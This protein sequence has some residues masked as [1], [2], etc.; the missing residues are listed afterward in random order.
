MR[1]MTRWFVPAFLFILT[2]PAIAQPRPARAPLEAAERRLVIPGTALDRLIRENSDVGMLR[3][4]EVN[5]DI[6]IPLWLRVYWRKKHP[7]G[8]YSASDPT[9]GYPLVLKELWE[10]MLTHQDLQ[11]GAPDAAEAAPL[12]KTASVSGELRTSGLQTKPRSES[13]IRVNPRNP[14]QIIAASNNIQSG[15]VQAQF[16]STDGGAT[17]SQSYLPLRS[18][19]VLHSDPTVEWTSDGTAWATTLGIVSLSNLKLLLYKSTDQGTTWTF[20]SV[21]SGSTQQNVD[22]QMT[23]VDSS[24]I[25]PYR[26][27]MYAIWHNNS[28]VFMNRRTGGAWQTPVQVSGS[29]TTGTGIGAD[30]RT[31]SAGEVYAFW[32]DTG[33]RKLYMVKSTNGGAAY[34][35]PSIVASTF[36]SYDIGVPAMNDRRV[37]VYATA[38]AYKTSLNNYVFLSWNDLSGASGC[39]SAANEPG[40]ST[41]SACKTRIWFTR[42]TNGGTSWS[43]PVM[44]NNQAS[45]N[46]QFNPWMVVDET[47]GR[48]AIVY[49]DTVGDAGRKKTDIYYQS[50]ADF[51][52][53]FS[54]AVKVTTAQTDESVAGADP[55]GN[56]YGDY[57]GLS[58]SASLFFPSWTD[59]RNNASEEIWTAAITDNG[60]TGP[61]PSIKPWGADRIPPAPPWWQTDDIWVD[62]DADGIPNEPGEPSRG[63]AN[64]QLTARITNRGS[65]AATNF[66]VTFRFKPYTTSGSA[67]AE[68]IAS[69]DESGSLAAGASKN[70]T[71]AWDLTDAFIQAHFTSMFWAADHFCVQ[72]T[73][74]STGSGTFDDVNLTDNFAQN[75]FSNV[76][77]KSKKASAK[78][79]LYN[80][81]DRV[82]IARLDV[83]TD[84]KGWNVRFDGIRNPDQIVMQPKQWIA[85]EAL[86]EADANTP[87]LARG[88][89]VNVDVSQ[90]LDGNIV[91]GLTMGLRPEEDFPG[92]TTPIG[93]RYALYGGVAT[94]LNRPVS[95]MARFYDPGETFLAFLERPFSDRY[96]LGLQLG[97]H[98]FDGH[99]EIRDGF[100]ARATNDLEVVNL[101]AYLRWTATAGALHPYVLVGPGAYHFR[102]S[103]QFGGQLGAGLDIPV[104]STVSLTTGVTLHAVNGGP[105]PTNLVWYDATFGVIF[106]IR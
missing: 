68:F 20:D 7:E 65:T 10:W 1:S 51:G 67:P 4:A 45:K 62:N 3:A 15:G 6:V 78:L 13:N 41:A 23:W 94:G 92:G 40:S 83:Q 24:P 43:S 84:V 64:N 39:T 72:V 59:R 58:G 91:G 47:N 79:Y 80:H 38:G 42:S 75:N 56:Q 8:N 36:D 103:S 17:W 93:S 34:S 18:G 54:S 99:C 21:V 52:A 19:D 86:V 73:V 50:S 12:T 22:K 71:V 37:L 25:S 33:S 76:P 5:D 66:R 53:T 31:N 81:Y 57:N 28:P 95:S 63:E 104:V 35:S 11:P 48:V 49:Y 70:Y 44:I 30:V 32:P 77:V 98:N 105:L 27:N 106:R 46:D 82:A 90:R 9:G 55:F 60:G 100:C 87:P 102:G 26:D 14:M 85:T 69:V 2:V 16:T 101:S 61:D 74:E 29:E 88:Q 97:Y 89:I 96:R